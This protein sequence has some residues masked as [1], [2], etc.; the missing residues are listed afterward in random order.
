[1]TH[2][3]PL[4]FAADL[5][6]L[7]FL[8]SFNI[9]LAVQWVH[10]ARG[11]Y[12]I[13]PTYVLAIVAL[14]VK[15]N[16]VHCPTFRSAGWNSAFE[17]WLSVLTAHPTSGILTSHNVLH[18][19]HNNTDADFVRCS[20]VRH[21]WNFI[22]LMMFF[23]A[24]VRTMYANK[25]SDLNNWRHSL[26]ELY[27]QA[28]AERIL[29]YGFLLVLVLLDWRSTL[30]YCAG[31]WVFAQ[32]VLVTINLLQHQDCDF[33]SEYNHSRN[34]TGRFLNWLLLNNGYHTAHH[35][36]PAAHWSKL[37]VIH[38]RVVTARTDPSLDE[39]SLWLCVWR[40]FVLGKGWQGSSA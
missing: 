19:G 37:P 13:L 15:H 17:V 29:T 20:L 30:K 10:I 32:W 9:L 23:F 4:R 1:M 35:M 6:T 40:R 33:N 39:R 7:A 16:H 31:P 21:R 28:I 24:S 36:F 34:L 3:V 14:V 8:V 12:L 18:H 38:Q 5:R 25:P 2:L 11:W 22:N 26:P 27:W